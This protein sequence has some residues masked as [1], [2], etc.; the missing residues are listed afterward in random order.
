[1]QAI[2]GNLGE[3]PPQNRTDIQKHELFKYLGQVG[4][5]MEWNPFKVR[6]QV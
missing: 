6:L 3:Y 2:T 1:M 4:K 5:T